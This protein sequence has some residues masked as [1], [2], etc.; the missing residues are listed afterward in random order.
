[1]LRPSRCVCEF[2]CSQ[3]KMNNTED[4]Y[5][6]THK[7]QFI[8]ILLPFLGVMLSIFLFSYGIS[9]PI[10]NRI[11]GDAFQ[12]LAIAREYS[13]F[14]DAFF[15][16]GT[17]ANGLPLFEFF[18]RQS[19]LANWALRIT[20]A[21]FVLH[22]IASFC[23]CRVAVKRSWIPSHGIWS[24]LLFFLLAAYP[25][26][27]LHT[28]TPLT[29]TFGS[30]I[31]IFAICFLTTGRW[32]QTI[33]GGM[34]LAYAEIVRPAYGL[35][36]MSLLFSVFV[37][38][39][40]QKQ[41]RRLSVAAIAV[42]MF[43]LAPTWVSC[44]FKYG[45]FSVQDPATFLP[46]RH[47]QM[48]LKGT[49]IL[50][51]HPKLAHGDE[52]PV[53][54]DR[55][56][57]EQFYDR[58]QLNAIFGIGASSLTGCLLATPMKSTIYFAKKQIGFF[59]S[60]RLQPYTELLTPDIYRWFARI[61][62]AF[63]LFG[64]LILI[65][66]GLLELFGGIKTIDRWKTSVWIFSLTLILTHSLLHVEE[67]FS[68]AWAPY[69]WIA[70]VYLLSQKGGK[71]PRARVAWMILGFMTIFIYFSQILSWDHLLFGLT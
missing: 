60:F 4:T 41:H 1:M 23:L 51:F 20:I 12:Y 57:Q 49:R 71:D 67:R 35:A 42:T 44:Y 15:H 45:S 5:F 64:E 36:I 13:S 43:C 37:I 69:C 9:L 47:A 46:V 63:A 68:L 34:L 8:K 48:G 65:I 32:V 22:I 54:H 66:T 19:D 50:W 58:C 38:S 7:K 16:V 52:F 31:L 24:G 55:F 26:A 70:L 59:D 25:P 3:N 40:W 30:D 27:V 11:R 28:T 18:F 56:L 61:W 21:M 39:F 6:Y 33:L 14:W 10:E 53:L 62:S 29:D 2:T 17:R